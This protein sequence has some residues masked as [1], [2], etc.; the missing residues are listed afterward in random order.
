MK[1]KVYTA[2]VVTGATKARRRV[3][4]GLQLHKKGMSAHFKSAPRING[5]ALLLDIRQYRRFLNG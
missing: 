5:D 1:L 2:W 3:V 4:S